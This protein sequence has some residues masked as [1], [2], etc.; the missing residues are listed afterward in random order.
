MMSLIGWLV[1]VLMGGTLAGAVAV[2]V[3]A[4]P[5]LPDHLSDALVAAVSAASVSLSPYG[6]LAL[7]IL[8]VVAT[9]LGAYALATSVVATALPAFSLPLAS[10]VAP[11]VAAP[12]PLPAFEG[13][14]FARGLMIGETAALNAAMLLYLPRMG[15]PLAL[16]ALMVGSLAALDGVARDGRYQRALAW[17][18]WLLP[19]SWLA[20]AVGL[21]LFLASV[22]IGPFV[23]M[24]SSVRVDWQMG[25]VETSGGFCACTGYRGGFSL[26]NFNFFSSPQ[27]AGAPNA[28]SLSAHESG[29][30]LNTA[31]M[32]GVMLWINALDENYPVFRRNLAYAELLAESRA[33]GL[34]GAP[35]H[36][37]FVRLW[38]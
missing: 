20:A 5:P 36:E 33:Q 22:L 32:G 38:G 31:A 16:W 6:M 29:H 3:G 4:R 35:R 18:S 23:R 1:G 34:S 2:V 28:P 9:Y 27:L 7:V 11:P 19:M 21:A 30:T 24:P 25:V 14:R 37:F 17:S 26:G 13:E 8:L 15:P 12:L 10:A